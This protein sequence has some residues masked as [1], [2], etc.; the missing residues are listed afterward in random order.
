MEEKERGRE[1]EKKHRGE[2]EA[3]LL[4]TM[5]CHKPHSRRC[6]WCTLGVH[7]LFSLKGVHSLF[8]PIEV[9]GWAWDG[10]D[11]NFPFF[12]FYTKSTYDPCIN[13]ILRFPVILLP[14]RWRANPELG[15]AEV[16]VLCHSSVQESHRLPRRL[17]SPGTLIEG[18][19]SLHLSII[20]IM[21]MKCKV[22]K[23][24]FFPRPFLSWKCCL[25][26]AFPPSLI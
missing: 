15:C 20:S 5:V 2:E 24:R 21:C 7:S 11:A 26:L 18:N 3:G 25:R 1:S 8:S 4:E 13:I 23:T 17:A 14:G 16:D 10:M 9:H 19:Y 12:L 22:S 6:I